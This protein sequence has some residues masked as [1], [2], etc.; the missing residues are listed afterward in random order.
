M[1]IQALTKPG[2][3]GVRTARNGA[4]SNGA[5]SSGAALPLYATITPGL[6]ALIVVTVMAATMMEFLDT[7][8]VNVAL[9]DMMGNLGATL[10]QIGWVSTGY[11][12]TNVIILPLTGWLSDY[13]GRKRYLTYSILLFTAASLACGFSHSLAELVFWRVAQGAGGA[14]FFSLSQATL[15]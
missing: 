6:R 7:T 5:G 12:I 14:A 1:A 4:T 11:I 8:I 2:A 15:M 10:D 3:A 9:P 13:F